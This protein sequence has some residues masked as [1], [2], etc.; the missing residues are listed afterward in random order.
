MKR[1]YKEDFNDDGH[2]AGGHLILALV[3]L[4]IMGLVA[5]FK[6]LF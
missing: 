6:W 5:L 2:Y 4:A 1:D 3:I